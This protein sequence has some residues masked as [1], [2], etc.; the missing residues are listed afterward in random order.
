[1]LAWVMLSLV[2]VAA[3]GIGVF[4]IWVRINDQWVPPLQ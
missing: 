4:L 1:M 2:I 3:V